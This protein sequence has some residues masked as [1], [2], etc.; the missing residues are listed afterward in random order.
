MFLWS[1]VFQMI[2]FDVLLLNPNQTKSFDT[3]MQGY[4]TARRLGYLLLGPR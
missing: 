1:P 3:K 2:F 4:V